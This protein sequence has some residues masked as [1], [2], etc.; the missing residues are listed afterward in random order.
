MDFF[1]FAEQIAQ[2]AQL[3]RSQGRTAVNVL[4]SIPGREVTGITLKDDGS[5]CDN[6]DVV[7]II[8]P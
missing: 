7:V 1:E 2:M 6:L 5:G 4:P 8:K 3:L